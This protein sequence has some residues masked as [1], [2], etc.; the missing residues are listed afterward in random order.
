MP[1]LDPRPVLDATL[2]MLETLGMPVGDHENP[3]DTSDRYMVLWGITG[4]QVG[5]SEG[6]PHEQ[7]VVVVQIDSSGHSRRQ[8]QWVATRVSRAMVERTSDGRGWTHPITVAG[9]NV[10]YREWQVVSQPEA[11]GQ[12]ETG[13]QLFTVRDRYELTVVPA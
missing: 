4:G 10:S 12:D 3:A 6:L 9:W 1:T 11:E 5:G 2:A 7:G 8:A 13:N